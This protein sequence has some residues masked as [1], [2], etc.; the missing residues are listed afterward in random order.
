MKKVIESST[1]HIDTWNKSIWLLTLSEPF[2][3]LEQIQDCIKQ[4]KTSGNVSD[5]AMAYLNGAHC[6]LLLTHLNEAKTYLASALELYE[7]QNDLIGI[8]LSNIIDGAINL[9]QGAL[10][11]AL[12]NHSRAVELA[13]KAANPYVECYALTNIGIVLLHA[14]EIHEALSYFMQ[15]ATILKNV[16]EKGGTR[17]PLLQELDAVLFTNLGEAF[18]AIGETDNATGYLELARIAAENVQDIFSEIK[19]LRNLAVVARRRREPD[20]A[21][22]LLQ[23]AINK[24]ERSEQKLVLIEIRIEQAILSIE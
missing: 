22:E 5:L 20:K 17:D 16:E 24:A 10:D 23:Q 11:Q 6:N 8:A 18:L 21:W 7:K 9:E 3:A 12:E 13:Q 19:I 15:A 14:E 4:T 2:K 1:T